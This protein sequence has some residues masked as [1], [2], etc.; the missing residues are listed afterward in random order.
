MSVLRQKKENLELCLSAG[1]DF[2]DME[3]RSMSTNPQ[4]NYFFAG[5]C[6]DKP[7]KGNN[8]ANTKYQKEKE[9]KVA[10]AFKEIIKTV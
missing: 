9:E 6:S 8:L 5:V 2:V 10:D 1:G 4:M 3:W 7:L